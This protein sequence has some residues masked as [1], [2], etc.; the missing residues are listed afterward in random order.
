MIHSQITVFAAFT[1]VL[2]SCE[3]EKEIVDFDPNLLTPETSL[4]EVVGDWTMT[5]LNDESLP[6]FSAERYEEEGISYELHSGSGFGLSIAADGTVESIEVDSQIFLIDGVIDEEESYT[7]VETNATG[8]MTR[9]D[10]AY[11]MELLFTDGETL[12][13]SCTHPET[14][15]ID[16]S[17][18]EDEMTNF[19][20]YE[21]GDAEK[22]VSDMPNISDGDET[23]GD[24]TSD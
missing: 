22:A 20:T 3:P 19:I 23:S 16:C 9:E 18:I 12:I 11:S 6:E 2:T 10:D 24:E 17:Y 13:F 15:K 14:A 8:T 4:D 7:F 1:I 5:S 21:L